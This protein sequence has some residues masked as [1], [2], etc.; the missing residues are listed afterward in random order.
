MAKTL[1]HVKSDRIGHDRIGFI[2]MNESPFSA[3]NENQKPA[4]SQ[5]HEFPS[6]I[7]QLAYEI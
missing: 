6:E 4:L 1:F 5:K 2:A 3:E 7:S